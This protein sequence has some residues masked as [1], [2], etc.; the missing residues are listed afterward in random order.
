MILLDCDAISKYY[1][2][3]YRSIF[4]DYSGQ[5]H[6][7]KVSCSLSTWLIRDNMGKL[8]DFYKLP[9]KAGYGLLIASKLG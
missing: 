8:A 2:N 6:N 5:W 7:I 9:L 4:C 3:Q 1:V